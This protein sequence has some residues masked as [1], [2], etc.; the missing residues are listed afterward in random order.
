MT[1]TKELARPGPVGGKR[2]ENRKLRRAELEKGAL[3]LFLVQGVE[4]TTIDDIVDRT[5][6]A[7]GSFY[8]YYKD[9]R[10]LVDALIEPVR[11]GLLEAFTNA[12][13]TIAR[14]ETQPALLEAYLGLALG[15]SGVLFEHRQ[16]ALLY[17]QESRAPGVG[18]RKPL[19]DMSNTI[20]EAALRLT[21]TARKRGLLR[22]IDPRVT[23]LAV[24]GATERLLF[25]TFRDEG[26]SEPLKVAE[27]LITMVM[28]GLRASSGDGEL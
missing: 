4:G 25:E 15:T 24:L 19:S 21:L 27:A 22:P 14:A 11:A 18:A 12:E 16:L 13:A 3:A 17:L 26:F 2:D 20:S 5:G 23:S 8:R 10:D 28:D 7:K 9:K 6:A 1:K